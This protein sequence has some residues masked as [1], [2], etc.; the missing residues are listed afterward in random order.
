MR[1][2]A[3]SLSTVARADLPEV[4]LAAAF[5]RE[6]LNAR[7]HFIYHVTIQKPGALDLGWERFRK[8]QAL[9]PKLGQHVAGSQE[10][11]VLRQ[12]TD[13]LAKDLPQYEVIL[14]RILD[15][16]APVS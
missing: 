6:I 5:E 7:I 10:L 2:A 9:M 14:R 15:V 3:K 16:A 4:A 1:Q 11:A 8:A 13:S 12:P